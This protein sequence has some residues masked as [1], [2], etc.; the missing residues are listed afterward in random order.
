MFKLEITLR[1]AP[2]RRFVFEEVIRV[3]KGLTFSIYIKRNKNISLPEALRP[4]WDNE[5]TALRLDMEDVQTF[6][7]S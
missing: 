7:I 5:D 2:G 1:S 3:A 6:V 4:F